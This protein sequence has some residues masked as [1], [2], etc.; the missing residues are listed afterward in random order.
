MNESRLM[1][2]IGTPCA[3]AC[4]K[5]LNRIFVTPATTEE[6]AADQLDEENR[7]SLFFSGTS[8]RPTLGGGRSWKSQPPSFVPGAV[9]PELASHMALMYEGQL[10]LATQQPGGLV[11]T[12][13]DEP[14]H[15]RAVQGRLGQASYNSKSYDRARS[16][17]R[18][19]S[20]GRDDG[21]DGALPPLDRRGRSF[22]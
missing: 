18:A 3:E 9:A 14:R 5:A 10:R 11:P 2:A 16:Y 20:Y 13:C 8:G 21:A 7:E 12:S 6:R 4:S 17:G 19:K 15:A 22:G 1:T